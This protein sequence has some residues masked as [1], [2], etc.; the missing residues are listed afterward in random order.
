MEAKRRGRKDGAVYG[1]EKE[2][3]GGVG[4]GKLKVNK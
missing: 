2:K 4:G 1:E 3:R